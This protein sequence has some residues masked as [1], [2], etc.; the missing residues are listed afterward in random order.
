MNDCA[1]GNGRGQDGGAG[2]G[3]GEGYHT[4][5]CSHRD[6]TSYSSGGIWSKDWEVRCLGRRRRSVNIARLTILCY[7]AS[8]DE[9]RSRAVC[10][11]I[12]AV[13]ECAVGSIGEEEVGR[14]MILVCVR[15]I[16]LDGPATL[17]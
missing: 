1:S 7:I 11:V 2:N 6:G 3:C 13:V 14:E 16:S 15:F 10:C 5:E 12:C 9:V 4:T 8:V 17:T